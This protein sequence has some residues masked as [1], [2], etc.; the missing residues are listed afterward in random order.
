MYEL[1]KY[2]IDVWIILYNILG[3]G[4]RMWG[5]NGEGLVKNSERYYRE[6]RLTWRE[7]FGG[8]RGDSNP[9]GQHEFFLK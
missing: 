6:R 7:R 2:I 9:T 3:E 8:G 5:K 4:C 1:E